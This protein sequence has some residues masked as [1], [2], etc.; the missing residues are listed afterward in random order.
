MNTFDI[1]IVV[2]T[3][4][5][6][7]RGLFR[8]FIKEFFSIIGVFVGFFLAARY[9]GVPADWIS[10]EIINP[11]YLPIVGFLAVFV[12]IYFI[13]SV[14]GVIIKY[15]LKITILGWVDRLF[16]AVS[17]IFKGVFTGTVLLLA[18]VTFLPAGSPAIT[19]SHLAPYLIS[20]TEKMVLVVPKAFRQQFNEKLKTVKK[21]LTTQS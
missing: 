7:I 4:F 13:I 15:L 20:T 10:G 1:L 19:R 3:G 12:F 6:L 16:G 17:G 18:L 14:L 9:Y 8:G 11:Q 21:G 5:C 2:I